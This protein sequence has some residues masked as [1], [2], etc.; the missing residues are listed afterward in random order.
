MKKLLIIFAAIFVFPACSSGQGAVPAVVEPPVADTQSAKSESPTV[1]KYR[2]QIKE[3]D[4]T[5]DYDL[6]F[7]DLTTAGMDSSV[8]KQIQ[9]Y[10]SV[11]NQIID[12][13]YSEQ[14]GKMKQR[15]DEY[16]KLSYK[17][18]MDI[19]WPDNCAPACGTMTTG[20]AYYD[21]LQ[22]TK[23]YLDDL[24]KAVQDF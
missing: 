23:K 19:S 3:C 7:G 16:I 9:C 22:V 2:A 18:S 5:A 24:I 1:Q 10:E 20:M 12:K 14:S 17:V 15:L 6:E 21:A 11:A 13:Y 4:K 8:D